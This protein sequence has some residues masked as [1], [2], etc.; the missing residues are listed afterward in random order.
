MPEKLPT[1]HVIRREQ[2]LIL[3]HRLEPDGLAARL[4]AGLAGGA[5]PEEVALG[6]AVDLNVVV[7]VVR[8]AA[9][10]P[11]PLVDTWG[12]SC[13]KS[14]KLRLSVGSFRSRVSVIVVEL[15]FCVGEMSAVAAD[16]SMVTIS[17]VAARVLSVKLMGVPD[18]G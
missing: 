1:A 6:G 9:E 7:P 4:T 13:T 16:A 3:L 10:R 8:A 14:E 11:G 17:S 2:H 18:R 5:E 15:P 12:V